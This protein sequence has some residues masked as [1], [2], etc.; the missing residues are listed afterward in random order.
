MFFVLA[1]MLDKFVYLRPGVAFILVFVGFKMALSA[2]I[3]IPTALSLVVIVLTLAAAMGLSIYRS[4]RE[5]GQ[6]V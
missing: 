4:S 3:H 1:G 2:W 5:A 6:P